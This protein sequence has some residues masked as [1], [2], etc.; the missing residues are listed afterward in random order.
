M[1]MAHYNVMQYT[2]QF[3]L[4]FLSLLGR[5]IDKRFYAL[6]GGCNLRFFLESFRYSEDMDLDVETVM[7]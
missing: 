1:K 3:H 7:R 5:K 6:K 2:E 4:L